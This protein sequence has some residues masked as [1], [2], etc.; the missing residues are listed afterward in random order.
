MGHMVHLVHV[1]HDTILMGH[2]VHLDHVTHETNFM[3]HMVPMTISGLCLGL[4]I[5]G[6]QG[7]GWF[8]VNISN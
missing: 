4:G 3:G 7:V 6:C 2:M 1:T 5:G 8:C